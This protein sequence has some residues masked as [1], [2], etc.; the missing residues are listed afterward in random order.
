MTTQ[1][2]KLTELKPHIFQLIDQF[3]LE[4]LPEVSNFLE[5]LLKF[6][7]TSDDVKLN[8]PNQSPP[9]EEQPWLKYTTI[10]KDSPNWD[11]FLETM[12]ENRR[13]E[14]KAI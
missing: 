5:L 14:D 1:P 13:E 11:E 2:P 9:T 7:H 12:A 10:L 3:P 8:Q 4:K 6:S